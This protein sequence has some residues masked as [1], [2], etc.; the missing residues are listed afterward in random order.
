MLSPPNRPQVGA[1]TEEGESGVLPTSTVMGIKPPAAGKPLDTTASDLSLNFPASDPKVKGL[2]PGSVIVSGVTPLTPYGMMRKVTAVTIKT[3]A[4][5]VDT[6]PA[7]LSDVFNEATI[8]IHTALTQAL[9]AHVTGRQSRQIRVNR[10]RDQLQICPNFPSLTVGSSGVQ[11]G[12]SSGGLG[13]VTLGGSLCVTAGNLQYQEYVS[14]VRPQ[15]GFTFDGG[16][17]LHVTYKLEGGVVAYHGDLITFLDQ[18]VG[19]IPLEEFGVPVEIVPHISSKL[20][21]D[22][23]LSGYV[24]GV[25]VIPEPIRPACPAGS[26][27]ARKRLILN[28]QRH[29]PDLA[30]GLPG[31][32]RRPGE[33]LRLQHL[34]RRRPEHGLLLRERSLHRFLRQHR[35]SAAGIVRPVVQLPGVCPA[36]RRQ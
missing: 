10:L 20:T 2:K 12:A 3:N 27:A 5:T 35:L 8:D 17:S 25:S 30:A 29:R 4:V 15:F 7:Q 18:D 9:M 22:L 28:T 24:Q 16:E 23:N 31:E 34:H 19:L 1:T 32:D 13:A 11:Q 26:P 6:V 14:K 21:A 33:R 36:G